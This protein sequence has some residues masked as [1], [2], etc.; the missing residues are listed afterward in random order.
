VD[1][2]GGQAVR[3]LRPV[4]AEGLHRLHHLLL[5]MQVERHRARPRER[6]ARRRDPPDPAHGLARGQQAHPLH[7]R[8]APPL[9]LRGPR[10]RPLRERPRRQATGRRRR[11]GTAQRC[12]AAGPASTARTAAARGPPGSSGPQRPRDVAPLPGGRR[13]RGERRRGCVLSTRAALP[14]AGACRKEDRGERRPRRRERHPRGLPVGTSSPAGARRPD[15]E[16]GLGSHGHRGA[17]P[18]GA[19]RAAHGRVRDG[20][21]PASPAGRDRRARPSCDQP[22]PGGGTVL[23]RSGGFHGGDRCHPRQVSSQGGRRGEG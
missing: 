14:P 16:A 8:L 7:L 10:L 3:A 21:V 12:R 19:V 5:G 9:P 11:R 4:P 15:R 23:G 20:Q 6:E 13:P 18:H 22:P 1:L 2:P 17:R